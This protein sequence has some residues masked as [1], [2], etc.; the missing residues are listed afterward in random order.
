MRLT[1]R[2]PLRALRDVGNR[3]TIME[4]V[5][6]IDITA[7]YNR[8]RNDTRHRRQTTLY[9]WGTTPT[10][11]INNHKASTQLLGQYDRTLTHDEK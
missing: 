2:Y 9:S 8:S 4:T 11:N 10:P 6:I 5:V 7:E 1:P 3:D